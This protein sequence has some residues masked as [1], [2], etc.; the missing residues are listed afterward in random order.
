MAPVNDPMY[1]RQLEN[2]WNK[3]RATPPYG[4]EVANKKPVD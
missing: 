1:Q 2:V 4:G 3:A